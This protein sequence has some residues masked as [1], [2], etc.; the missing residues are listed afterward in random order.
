MNEILNHQWAEHEVFIRL[1][2]V[3]L[4][5]HGG[6]TDQTDASTAFHAKLQQLTED[7]EKPEMC[8]FDAKSL[9]N[10]YVV[11]FTSQQQVSALE[12]MSSPHAAT[13][14]LNVVEE[15]VSSI[16]FKDDT[17]ARIA[18]VYN[19]RFLMQG[20][21]PA[22]S[23]QVA[24]SDLSKIVHEGI[25]PNASASRDDSETHTCLSPEML[26]QKL[27][28]ELQYCRTQNQSETASIKV[29]DEA[30]KM[31]EDY[32]E[33]VREKR[34]EKIA[35]QKLVLNSFLLF[36]QGHSATLQELDTLKLSFEEVKEQ[37]NGPLINAYFGVSRTAAKG[38]N[39]KSKGKGGQRKNNNQQ[40]PQRKAASDAAKQSFVNDPARRD[41]DGRPVDDDFE[42]LSKSTMYLLSFIK[43]M[44]NSS[45]KKVKEALADMP[46][47]LTLFDMISL[48]HPKE[49]FLKQLRKQQTELKANNKKKNGS[50]QAL[51]NALAK[52][53]FAITIKTGYKQQGIFGKM[54][55]G[56]ENEH[57]RALNE[58]WDK[59]VTNGNFSLNRVSD[60]LKFVRHADI[61]TESV[62]FPQDPDGFTTKQKTQTTAREDFSAQLDAVSKT[63]IGIRLQNSAEALYVSTFLVKTQLHAQPS[64]QPQPQWPEYGMIFYNQYNQPFQ[65]V[66]PGRWIPYVIRSPGSDSGSTVSTLSD[67]STNSFLGMPHQQAIDLDEA[68]SVNSVPSLPQMQHGQQQTPHLHGGGGDMQMQRSQMQ[69]PGQLVT[70]QPQQQ[71]QQQLQ[72]QQQFQMQQQQLQMQQQ[73]H[74]Q[75]QQQ[76]SQQAQIVPMPPPPMQQPPQPP[77]Q[78]PDDGLRLS[79]NAGLNDGTVPDK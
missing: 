51:S 75:Q 61:V 8:A 11:A 3:A 78:P 17:F 48:S 23:L 66:P 34:F 22:V 59:A 15:H 63:P 53:Q 39:G 13:L 47:V 4:V 30:I 49:Q 52:A 62:S 69:Q 38:N 44:S 19:M 21:S 50:R 55:G 16:D 24:L 28:L 20:C 70:V 33:D 42:S 31:L 35:K 7:L 71:M 73:H 10:P 56:F 6:G 40:D 32:E 67:F 77:P 37:L 29:L 74:M 41:T 1:K 9:A 18:M 26:L 60:I 14:L 79:L 5:T 36:F 43:Q 76:M 57:Y 12:L 72:M 58:I 2:I 45:D 25:T 46:D 54:K 64:N 27:K 65:W 68:A